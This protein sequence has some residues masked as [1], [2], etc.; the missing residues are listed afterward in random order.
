LGASLE[1]IR[2]DR[3]VCVLP[4]ASAEPHQAVH[5]HHPPPAAELL[6]LESQVA[7]RGI[8]NKQEFKKEDGGKDITFDKKVLWFGLVCVVLRCCGLGWVGLGSLVA[9]YTPGGDGREGDGSEEDDRAPS[10]GARQERDRQ[11]GQGAHE[12]ARCGHEPHLQKQK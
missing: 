2:V 6:R 1:K 8:M 12:A 7:S 3:L 11:R 10:D 4:D 5:H 9:L